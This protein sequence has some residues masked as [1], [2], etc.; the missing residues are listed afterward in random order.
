MKWL[1]EQRMGIILT[2]LMNCWK[3]IILFQSII[4]TCKALATGMYKVSNNISPAIFN[5]IF[6]SR[7]TP[8]NLHKPVSFNM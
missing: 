7:A 5:A 1:K 2:Y 3:K 8:Y 6:A 4:K